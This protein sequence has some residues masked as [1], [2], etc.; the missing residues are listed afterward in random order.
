[1]MR[2]PRNGDDTEFVRYVSDRFG[3][4]AHS[5]AATQSSGER[6]CYIALKCSN[7]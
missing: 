6:R 4:F 5:G 1:M 7:G 2:R 3:P